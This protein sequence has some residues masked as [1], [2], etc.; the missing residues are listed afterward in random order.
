M[1]DI[2]IH[3][4]RNILKQFGLKEYEIGLDRSQTGLK[5]FET[6]EN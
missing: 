5:R 2:R 6:N 1:T 4:K 3:A